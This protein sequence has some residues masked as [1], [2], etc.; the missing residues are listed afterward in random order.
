MTAGENT[1]SITQNGVTKSFPVTA[2]GIAV[3]PAPSV[4]SLS[5]ES[6]RAIGG[7]S[8]VITGTNLPRVLGDAKD[9]AKW[10]VK[11]CNTTVPAAS[12]TAVNTLSAAVT[13]TVTVPNLTDSAAGLGVG[14]FAGPCPVTV[15][16]VAAGEKSS[17][18]Q[19]S[20]YTVLN[21]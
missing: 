2:T 18:S 13:V 5:V 19:G 21:E 12:I 1:V 4:T 17:I 9:P 7:N 20:T 15:T 6:G 11:F 3:V 16:D 14:T 8:T 10:L